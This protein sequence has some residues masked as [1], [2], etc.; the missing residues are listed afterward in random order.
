[1][2]Y[3]FLTWIITLLMLLTV[4]CDNGSTRENLEHAELAIEQKD[5]QAARGICDNLREIQNHAETMDAVTLCNLSMLYMKLSDNTDREDN[6]GLARQC[7]IDAYS[8]D[9]AQAHEYYDHV[10]VEDLPHLSLLSSIV[11]STTGIRAEAV[12]EYIDEGDSIS[13]LN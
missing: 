5:Y 13:G 12:E 10:P 9:S 4:A 1:M 7:Y 8:T 2:K 11:K 6:I 3:H